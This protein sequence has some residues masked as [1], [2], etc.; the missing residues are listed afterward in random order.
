MRNST[1]LIKRTGIKM[2]TLKA[3]TN[4]LEEFSDYMRGD[5]SPPIETPEYNNNQKGLL[6]SGVVFV[7]A[8]LIIFI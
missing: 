5:P 2:K 7:I 3:I 4:K 1:K 6:F 8:M